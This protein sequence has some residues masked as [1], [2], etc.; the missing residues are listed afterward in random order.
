MKAFDLCEL[1]AWALCGAAMVMIA[2]FVGYYIGW[3]LYMSCPRF[4]RWMDKIK[5]EG[6]DSAHNN[7]S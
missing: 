2:F 1:L 4:R 5:M 3:T 7:K 6:Y